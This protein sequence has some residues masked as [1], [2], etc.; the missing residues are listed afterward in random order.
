MFDPD[1]F[2]KPIT[3]EILKS[4]FPSQSEDYLKELFKN[5][6]CGHFEFDPEL[7]LHLNLTLKLAYN[8]KNLSQKTNVK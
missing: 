2:T 7:N 6:P 3:F 4:T 1:V 5:E 8:L